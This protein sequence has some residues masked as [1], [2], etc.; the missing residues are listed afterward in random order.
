MFLE[1]K[2]HRKTVEV[3]PDENISKWRPCFADCCWSCVIGH[4]T[5]HTPVLVNSRKVDWGSNREQ[6]ASCHISVCPMIRKKLWLP[7]CCVLRSLPY[8][9]TVCSSA[10]MS[11][12]RRW[13]ISVVTKIR[14]LKIQVFLILEYA[15]ET[16]RNLTCEDG[17][18]FKIFEFS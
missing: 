11:S 12:K 15:E 1:K 4:F 5:D 9:C 6:A 3:R 14:L 17:W 2:S 13:K 10:M 18:L 8:T 7:T 16:S